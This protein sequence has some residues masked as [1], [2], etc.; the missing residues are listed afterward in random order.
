MSHLLVTKLTFPVRH[1]QGWSDIPENKRWSGQVQSYN[2][3][4]RFAREEG[5]YIRV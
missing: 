2:P 1:E 5:C 4:P 3:R